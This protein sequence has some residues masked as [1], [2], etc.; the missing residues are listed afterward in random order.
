MTCYRMTA[1]AL[2]IGLILWAPRFSAHHSFAVAFDAQKMIVLSGAV[3]RVELVSPHLFIYMD[4]KDASG[5][6]QRWALEGPSVNQFG[7]MGLDRTMF[8]IGDSLEVCGYGTK[9]DS[10][11]R[12]DN[13]KSSRILSSELLILSTGQKIV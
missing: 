13:G 8:K 4:I 2:G 11:L 5:Q 6:T 3:A 12:V 10:A 1:V 9:D 7:R